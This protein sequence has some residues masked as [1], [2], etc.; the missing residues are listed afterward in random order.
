GYAKMAGKYK[1]VLQPADCQ[2]AIFAD[3]WLASAYQFYGV[4]LG[5]EPAGGLDR[6]NFVKRMFS[7]ASCGA[8]QLFTYEFEQHVPEIQKYLRL[9]TGVPG[10]TQ[11]ALY[12]PTTLYR[13]GGDLKPTIQFA[14]ALRDLCEFEVLDEGLISDGG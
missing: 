7:D 9:Y 12:C 13:L 10:D 2:G 11:I 14:S 4:K 5:T 8:S 1:I 3:K 6:N